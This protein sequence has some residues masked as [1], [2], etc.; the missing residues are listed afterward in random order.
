MGRRRPSRV[1]ADT[2]R[3]GYIGQL[4][5]AEG[6]LEDAIKYLTDAVSAETNFGSPGNWR[7]STKLAEALHTAGRTAEAIEV[8]ETAT[9]ARG[10]AATGPSSGYAWI[11]AREQLSNLYR[12]AGREA[13]ARAVRS[14]L[15]VLLSVADDDHPVKL[16]IVQ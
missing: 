1:I 8:L 7:M 13:D 3:P 10:R 11:A 6:R 4:A 12:A 16:R 14:Q 5:L 2:P 15:L 9:R